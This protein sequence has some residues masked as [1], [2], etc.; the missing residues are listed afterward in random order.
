MKTAL[1]LLAPLLAGLLNGCV[2]VLPVS[3][4]GN[5]TVQGKV[6]TRAAA[7]FILLGQ[8][9]R[10]QVVAR[11]GD[12]YR[13]SPRRSVLAYAW[14]KPAAGL[15]WWIVLVGPGGGGAAGG[16]CER[17]QWSACFLEFDAANRVSRTEF[18]ALNQR[19]SLDEQMENWAAR[20]HKGFLETGGG[21]FNPINGHPC[22]MDTLAKN[23]RAA[24]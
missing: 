19:E 13:A 14:E 12:E 20:C 18:V 21:V 24:K 11:W 6:I 7:S 8:T 22:F 3:S 1:A 2:G 10:Q 16:H 5:Q 4:G 15:C 17:S 9:T 23:S